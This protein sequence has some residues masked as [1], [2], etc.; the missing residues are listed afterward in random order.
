[1]RKKREYALLPLFD[2]LRDDSISPEQRL[3]FMPGFAFFIMAFGDLNKYVLR[4]DNPLDACQEQVNMHTLEDDHHWPWYLEDLQKLGYDRPTTMVESLRD[5]WSDEHRQ[6]RLLMYR[7]C[8]MVD[9]ANGT[10][11]L[12]IIEAIEETG[13]V[14]FSLTARLAHA[15]HGRTGT[16]LRYCGDFHLA[17]ESGH[18]QNGDHAE[19]ARISLSEDLR[20]RCLTLVD[21]VFEAFTAWTY[22]AADHIRRASADKLFIPPAITAP[23]AYSA[24]FV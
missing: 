11:R 19:L 12:A 10:E 4:T 20:L 8:A 14:L 15:I 5:L 9:G 22:E 2:I 16:D 17:L 21:Q 7:M 1:M 18:A 24:R 3:G 23:I 13:H 6:A